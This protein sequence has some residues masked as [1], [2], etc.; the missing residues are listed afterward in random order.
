MGHGRSETCPTMMAQKLAELNSRLSAL[1]WQRWTARVADGG[2]ALGLLLVALLAG[3]FLLDW[4]FRFGRGQRGVM[5]VA[6][7]LLALWGLRRFV[8]PALAS[9]ESIIDVAL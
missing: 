5:L 2:M 9:C 4:E 7:G 3:E 1:R 8:W 6:V